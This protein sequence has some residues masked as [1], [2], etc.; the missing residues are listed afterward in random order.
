MIFGFVA[1]AGAVILALWVWDTVKE[2]KAKKEAK[3]AE[4]A[5]IK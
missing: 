5:V 3:A 1:T 4:T 2:K